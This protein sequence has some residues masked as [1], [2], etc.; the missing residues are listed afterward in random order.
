ML[1]AAMQGAQQA[2]ADTELFQLYDLHY[3]GCKSCFACK[4]KGNNVNGLCAVKDELQPLL[5]KAVCADVLVIGSPVYDSFPT[6]MTRSFIERLVFPAVNYCD[7]ASPKIR[8]P[9]QCACIYTMNAPENLMQPLRYDTI[10]GEN[11]RVLGIF[12]GKP[13]M[14]CSH[15]T[16]QFNDYSRYE[17]AVEES[18]RADIRA[19]RFPH[20]LQKAFELGKRLVQKA[21][22]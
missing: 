19:N 2:G 11:C 6:G 17:T 18:V 16:Y 20:D 21:K 3:Q 13:E 22:E 9:I 8:K 10:L 12:G 7:Y 4:L 14:L 1:E 15:E 5:E